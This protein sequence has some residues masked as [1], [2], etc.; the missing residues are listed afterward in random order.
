MLVSQGLV[1]FPAFVGNEADPL[2]KFSDATFHEECFRRDPSARVVEDRVREAR[3]SCEPSR[4][5]CRVCD[6]P[7]TKP[8]EYFGLGHLTSDQSHALHAFNY[9]HLHRVC[10]GRWKDLALVRT[11]AAKQLALGAWKGDGM[12]RLLRELDE[13]TGL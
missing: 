1:S 5:R 3:A 10:L 8:D 13:A 12:R 6:Q 9:A 11:F 4:R 7:I 2:L